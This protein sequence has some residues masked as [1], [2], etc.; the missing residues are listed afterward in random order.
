MIYPAAVGLKSIRFV[1]TQ[2]CNRIG[3]GVASLVMALIQDR[4]TGALKAA[5]VVAVDIDPEPLP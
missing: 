2:P 4:R 5:P 3:Y 1:L